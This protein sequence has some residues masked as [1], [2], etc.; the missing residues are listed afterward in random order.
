MDTFELNK[1]AGAILGSLLLVMGIGFLADLLYAPPALEQQAY[2]VEV[3]EE[4]D[5]HGAGAE[6]EEESAPLAVVLAAGDAGKGERQAKKCA[7]C[8]TFES[9]GAN[10][11]GPNLH[12]VV[13]R[14]KGSHEGFAY[15]SAME[16]KAGEP[17]TYEDLFGFIAA[18]K[19]WLS[20]TTMAFAGLKKP[21]DRADVIA[22]LRTV[23]P[24]APP[25]PEP[26]QQAAVEEAAP[27]QASDTAAP[28]GD[29][30]A[31]AGDTATSGDAPASAPAPA[32]DGEASASMPQTTAPAEPVMPAE[33][34]MPEAMA[35]PAEPAPQAA[36]APAGGAN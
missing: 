27:T 30:T 18:P 19:Q 7:A 4:A 15:S 21:E 35:T 9:G 29:S 16:A 23:S 6:P 25:L 28:E 20:G 14:A 12:G 2:V 33:P 13:G 24:D 36:P 8:H 1:F 10:K 3:P 11:V 34:A 22:Y 26:E 17:W 32:S 31:A 5:G